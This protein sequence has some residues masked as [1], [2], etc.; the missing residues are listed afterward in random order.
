MNITLGE[1]EGQNWWCVL[2]PPLC[3]LEEGTEQLPEDEA[4]KLQLE[5]KVLELMNL[6]EVY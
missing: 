6:E 4:T 2:F 5:W 1:G 3:L